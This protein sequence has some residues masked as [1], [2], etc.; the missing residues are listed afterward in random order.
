L[1]EQGNNFFLVA[2]FYHLHF[3]LRFNK[4]FLTLQIQLK[5]GIGDE[6]RGED[7]VTLR[8]SLIDFNQLPQAS[9]VENE[10]LMGM[11]NY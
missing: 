11:G 9:L 4:N 2:F 3:I 7:G 8:I 10:N 6:R 1:V 5:E